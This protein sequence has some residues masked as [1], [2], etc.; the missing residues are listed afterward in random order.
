MKLDDDDW[1][2]EF[3]RKIIHGIVTFFVSMITAIIVTLALTA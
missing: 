3:D 2:K 1:I